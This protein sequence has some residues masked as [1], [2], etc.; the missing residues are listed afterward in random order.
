M[1]AHM[2]TILNIGVWI[3]AFSTPSFIDKGN[4]HVSLSP[5][6]VV[7]ILYVKLD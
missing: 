7:V 2:R 4:T 1:Q 6:E 3:F 5:C